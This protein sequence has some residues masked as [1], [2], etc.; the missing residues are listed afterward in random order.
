M[1][2]SFPIFFLLTILSC[3]VSWNLFCRGTGIFNTSLLYAVVNCT[4]LKLSDPSFPPVT[5]FLSISWLSYNCIFTPLLRA[6]VFWY[7]LCSFFEYWNYAALMLPSAAG[8]AIAINSNLSL[9]ILSLSPRVSYRKLIMLSTI[10]CLR[11][12]IA[13]AKTILFSLLLGL[14]ADLSYVFP[15]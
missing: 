9:P 10:F 7:R 1:I 12:L 14:R 11:F 6:F 2:F 13:L 15:K 4:L 5:L 3:S 8:T